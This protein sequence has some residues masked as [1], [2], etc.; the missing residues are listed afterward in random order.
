MSSIPSGTTVQDLA[1]SLMQTFDVNRDN[2]L[3]SD[4]F[5]TFLSKLLTGVQSAAANGAAPA[6]GSG[7]VRLE[8]FDLGRPQ[9]VDRSAKD[10]FAM[11]AQRAGSM[12][13]SKTEAEQWFNTNIRGE[14]ERLGHRVNWVKGDKF[15]FSNWQGTFVVD[16]VRGADSGDAALTWQVE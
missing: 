12:P 9:Q 10:A 14:M 13:R 6:L 8:G 11:L 16:F 2:Q 5:S 15:Q 7:G 4:E 1:R 3:T